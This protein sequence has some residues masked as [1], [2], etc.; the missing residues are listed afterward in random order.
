MY[1]TYIASYLS[2]LH[3][4]NTCLILKHTH[5]Y[6]TS[7]HPNLEIPLSI[8]LGI[9][10]HASF[11][12]KKNLK[13]CLTYKGLKKT[14]KVNFRMNTSIYIFYFDIYQ[15]TEV[16]NSNRSQ[17]IYNIKRLINIFLNLIKLFTFCQKKSNKIVH[18]NKYTSKYLN[19]Y[20]LK[21]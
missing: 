1:L 16:N 15:Y 14:F 19:K 4:W 7:Y 6:I 20:V 3:K 9:V 11:V 5:A 17:I 8:N 2:P 13:Y 21:I 10:L 12:I 18:I